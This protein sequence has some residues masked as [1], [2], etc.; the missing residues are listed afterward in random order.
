MTPAILPTGMLKA[1]ETDLL[2]MAGS[3]A[4]KLKP[5]RAFCR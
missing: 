3:Q 1:N 2:S 5:L 4:P